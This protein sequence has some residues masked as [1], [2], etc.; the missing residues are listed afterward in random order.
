MFN[1]RD[2]G[3]ERMTLSAPAHAGARQG[4][5][6]PQGFLG[7][8]AVIAMRKGMDLALHALK[9]MDSI[10]TSGRG[11]S[12]GRRK[13]CSPRPFA[14]VALFLPLQATV[15]RLVSLARPLYAHQSRTSSP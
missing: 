11:L 3:D 1:V 12:Q 5:A 6:L 9:S 7:D 4:S 14:W 13:S 10:S 2:T 8:S 15:A